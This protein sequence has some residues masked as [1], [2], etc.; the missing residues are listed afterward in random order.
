MKIL[1]GTDGSEHSFKAIE[2]AAK[3]AAAFNDAEITVVNVDEVIPD[4]PYYSEE[5]LK[6]MEGRN[7]AEREQILAEAVRIFEGKNIKFNT[8]IRKGHAAATIIE[9]AAEGKFVVIGSRGLGGFKQ[10]LLG[11]VSNAVAQAVAANVLIVK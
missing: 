3:I 10:A 11:S 4:I 8:M 9:L 1:V 7:R 5:S 6:Q 2:E